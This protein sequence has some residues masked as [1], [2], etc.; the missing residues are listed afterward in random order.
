MGKV[1]MSG[2]TRKA[3]VPL[4]LPDVGTSLGVCTWEEVRAISDAGQ[5]ANYFAVGDTMSIAIDGTVGVTTF[6]SLEVD[7]FIIG[8]DHNLIGIDNEIAIEG[9]GIHFQIG[10]IGG[11]DACLVDSS[12]NSSASTSGSFIMNTSSSN[13]GGWEACHMRTTVLGSDGDP[14]NPAVNTLLAAL[15]SDLRAVI[16]CVTK[17]TNND[18]GG[19]GHDGVA[20]YV[21]ATKDCLWLLSEFEVTG[22]ISR[23]SS[24]EEYHQAQYD[25]YKAGNSKVKYRHTATT[26]TAIW[27]LRSP[28]ITNTTYFCDV[29]TNG[30]MGVKNANY[31]Y[32]ISP[33]F[34]V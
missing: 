28:A 18:G 21:T 8:I 11:A 13:T 27:W 5:A 15:P 16:K 3:S 6:S 33:A 20:E 10:K 23:A 14:L 4:A 24:S 19:T 34:C 9:R 29:N 32:G 26:T 17:Y 1:M 7:A 22:G 2:V 31:S 12:Y 30:S 25:Y